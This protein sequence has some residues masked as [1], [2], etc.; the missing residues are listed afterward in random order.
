[1]R[2]TRMP[3]RKT[4]MPRQNRKRRAKRK[5]EQYGPQAAVVHTLP[6]YVCALRIYSVRTLDEVI[7]MCELDPCEGTHAHHEPP[8]GRGQV[9]KDSD[10]CPLCV[11]HHDERHDIGIDTFERKYGI[12][13][14][15]LPGRIARARQERAA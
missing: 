1:M 2:R 5:A 11:V 7:A 14:R 12:D 8:I 4:W 10:T 3:D 6:C 13:L 9:G 15:G